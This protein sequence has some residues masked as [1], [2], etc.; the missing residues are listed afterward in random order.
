MKAGLIVEGSAAS[1]SGTSEDRRRMH[2]S[3]TSTALSLVLALP[4]CVLALTASAQ[5]A[6]EAYN[7]RAT[8]SGYSQTDRTAIL[9][10]SAGLTVA[11]ESR[12]AKSRNTSARHDTPRVHELFMHSA[13]RGVAPFPLVLNQTVRRYIDSFLDQPAL[14]RASF[15][16]VAP[17][18]S[19]MVREFESRGLP[20]DLVY[21][22]FAESDFSSDGAGL[23]Q[24]SRAT[25]RRFGLR[26]NRYVDERR[27]PAKSTHAAA[28][29]LA[30]LHDQIGDWRLT[31]ASW[32]RGDA[33]IDRFWSLRGA[34]YSRILRNLPRCTAILLNR[35][36]AVTFIAHNAESYGVQPIQYSQPPFERIKVNGGTRLSRVA[37]MAGT[38]TQLIRTLNPAL[39]RDRVPPDVASYDVWVPR[40]PDGDSEYSEEF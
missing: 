4:I 15:E 32:N 28:E 18:L 2:K 12:A 16:S 35:F 31:V 19:E 34:D 8:I 40:V 13:P 17:Y 11:P 23:W 7:A 38:T 30:S 27:D 20:K 39:L 25:A 26:I 22:A 14:L 9:G 3:S 33:S 29:Y 21:L 37:E 10:Q 24:L 5:A 6:D 36:M 1:V